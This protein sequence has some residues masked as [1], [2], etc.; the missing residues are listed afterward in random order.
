MADLDLLSALA[1]DQTLADGLAA[2][3]AALAAQLTAAQLQQLT[4]KVAEQSPLAQPVTRAQLDAAAVRTGPGFEPDP[5]LQDD[6]PGADDVL[7]FDFPKPVQLVWVRSRGGVARAGTA[8]A[9]PTASRGIYCGDDE[10]TPITV[11]SASIRV[12]APAGST[13]SCWAHALVGQS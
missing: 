13:V 1:K 6:Q 11:N 10:P 2:V 7:D 4:L 12:F 3:A 8:A 9:L 5:L